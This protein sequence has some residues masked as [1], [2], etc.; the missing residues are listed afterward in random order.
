MESQATPQLKNKQVSQPD[1]QLEICISLY[2]L[3][4]W[5]V[6]LLWF[7]G[8]VLFFQGAVASLHE[9][10]YKAAALFAIMF[11]ILLLA[12]FVAWLVGRSKPAPN[13]ERRSV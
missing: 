8:E 10:E 12:M 6:Y 2:P 11:A 3:W 13:P 7:V 4:K 5:P 9:L 1:H